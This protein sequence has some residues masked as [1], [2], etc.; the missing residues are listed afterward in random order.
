[1]KAVRALPWLVLLLALVVR[2]HDWASYPFVYGMDAHGHAAYLDILLDEGHQPDPS[3]SWA[4]YHPPGYYLISAATAKLLGW[5][6][7][8][9]RYEAAKLVSALAGVIALAFVYLAA[10]KLTPENSSWSVLFLATLPLALTMSCQVYNGSL[11]LMLVTGYLAFMILIWEEPPTIPSEATAGIL[12]GLAVL[13]RTDAAVLGALLLWRSG[14]LAWKA[15]E[16]KTALRDVLVGLL[17]SLSLLGI[18][19]GWFFQKNIAQFNKPL[20]SNLAQTTFP[21]FRTGTLGLPGQLTVRNFLDTGGSIWQKPVAPIGMSSVPACLYASFWSTHC[22]GWPS[23]EG[24][25]SWRLLAGVLPSFVCLL[26]LG[27][28]IRRESWQ[29]LYGAM[30]LNILAMFGLITNL[31]TY[32]GYKA[33]YLYP[34][35]LPLALAFAAGLSHLEQHHQRVAVPVKMASAACLGFLSGSLWF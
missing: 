16:E 22:V 6:S 35:F 20:V 27:V 13:V 24:L 28:T 31:P 7:P 5:S 21:V 14:R 11:A 1:M 15:R 8:P 26:G 3:E 12:L 17:F 29:P 25:A 19:T 9:Q 4:T 18:L 33:V 34:C 2:T 23:L 10:R 30:A 32:T